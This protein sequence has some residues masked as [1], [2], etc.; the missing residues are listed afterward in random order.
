MLHF[1]KNNDLAKVVKT[2]L[3]L[4]KFLFLD[5]IANSVIFRTI[6]FSFK[7][8]NFLGFLLRFGIKF[9]L[10]FFTRQYNR[11]QKLAEY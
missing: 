7:S 10:S 3:N 4:L 6:L 2:L 8:T 9:Y 1:Y 5:S 11:N